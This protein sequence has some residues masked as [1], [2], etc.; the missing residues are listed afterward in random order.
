M[1]T[2]VTTRRPGELFDDSRVEDYAAS[3]AAGSSI[4]A[5]GQ[6]AGFGIATAKKLEVDPE[7]RK[8]IG[9]L[10][11]R[12]RTLFTPSPAAICN[13]LME[14]VK[15]ARAEKQFKPAV[16]ALKLVHTVITTNPEILHGLPEKLPA[17]PGEFREAIRGFLSGKPVNTTAED[18]PPADEAAQ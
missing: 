11:S 10:R 3:R 4:G 1:A 12:S 14:I 5:A 2:P 17:A 13:E 7:V 6:I 16:E 9:E 15:E 18:V 8:R